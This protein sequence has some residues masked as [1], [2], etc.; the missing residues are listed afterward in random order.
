MLFNLSEETRVSDAT[1]SEEQL[2]GERVD[3]VANSGSE[4]PVA[5]ESPRL[6]PTAV[7][8]EHSVSEGSHHISVEIAALSPAIITFGDASR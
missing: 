2:Y 3:R 7:L 5:C 8:T 6:I 4:L 1:V